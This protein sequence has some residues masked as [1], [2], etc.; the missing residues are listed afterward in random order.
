M[1]WQW[2]QKVR[3]PFP[4][5]LGGILGAVMLKDQPLLAG[6]SLLLGALAFLYGV[7][8]GRRTGDVSPPA[9]EA[10]EE[11]PAEKKSHFVDVA[12]E[13][14]AKEGFP[15][16]NEV[17]PIEWVM[18]LH[19]KKSDT[20]Q[21]LG[22][23]GAVKAS[24]SLD[25]REA[26]LTEAHLKVLA[27]I[28]AESINENIIVKNY[29]ALILP[30]SGN[31]ILGLTVAQILKLPSVVIRDSPLDG[32]Y[33]ESAV[34]HGRGLLLDDVGTDGEL[35]VETAS[36]AREAGFIVR[37]AFVFVERSEGSA[38]TKLD[39]HRL[40]LNAVLKLGDADFAA[41]ESKARQAAVP[42]G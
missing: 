38:R 15:T 11:S 5:A 19:L 14:V 13:Q 26:V 39:E 35:L 1:D 32:Q 40:N 12:P 29:H 41:L 4:V 24:Y 6:G 42:G 16:P 22:K 8:Q 7:L 33:V 23:S 25:L 27:E 9:V 2:L 10:A 28:L 36:R 18:F 34:T 37:E 3:G 20:P 21:T 17:S 30:K 31:P